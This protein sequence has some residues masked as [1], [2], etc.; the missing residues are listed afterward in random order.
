[1][2]RSEMQAW[3]NDTIYQVYPSTFNEDSGREQIG[4]GSLRGVT[5]KLEYLAELGIDAVWLSPFFVSPKRDGGYDVAD[6]TSIDPMYGTL[7]DFNQ[8]VRAA[9]E[10]NMKIMI[11]FVPNHTSDQHEWFQSSRLKSGGKDDWYIWSDPVYD[12]NGV[13]RPPNNWASVFSLPQLDRRRNGELGDMPDGVPT[14]PISAW[15]WDEERGQYYLHSFASFQPDL[16]WQNPEVREA[17]KA[18][19]RTWLDRGVDAFRIDAVNYIAKNFYYEAGMF[20]GPNEDVNTAY[21]EGVDNPYDQLIRHHSCGYPKVLHE[22]LAELTDVLR[23]PAYKKRESRIIFEMYMSEHELKKVDRL[24]PHIASTFNFAPIDMELTS[25]TQSRKLIIDSY[26][27]WM[28]TIDCPPN[29]VMGNHDKP[30]AVTRHGEQGARAL[31]IFSIL[32]PGNMV[33]YNGEELGRSDHTS[34]PN[35]R[36]QDPNGLRDGCRTPMPWRLDEPNS[37]FSFADE[38]RLYLPL[39]PLDVPA[40]HQTDNNSFLKLYRQSIALRR[41]ISSNYMPLSVQTMSSDADNDGVIAYGRGDELTVITNFTDA[42]QHVKSVVPRRQPGRRVLSSI[43]G[44][45]EKVGAPETASIKLAPL[46]SIV[47]DHRAQGA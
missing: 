32:Q 44:L 38:S 8:L 22:H 47:I 16:N 2:N 23:E 19:M 43:T 46:E 37:G 6:M 18:V 15:S 33:I 30:R 42:I 28:Q 29:N 5:E 21:R 17:L 10:R 40:D 1:M 34:I 24:D 14:P 25:S 39:N 31:A 20:I 12:E 35:N 26:H 3:R 45:I 9:H 4:I 7:D 11:D 27:D 36:I 41:S 13:R